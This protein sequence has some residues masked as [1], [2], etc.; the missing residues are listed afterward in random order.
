MATATKMERGAGAK[1]ER[2]PMEFLVFEDNGAAFH[3]KIVAGDG[4]TLAESMGYG[5][6]DEAEQAAG[7]VRDGAASA[8]F[9]PHAGGGHAVDLVARR[10]AV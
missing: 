7:Y 5:S 8:S 1:P 4:A 6:Y 2:A 9:G 3:W 10:A